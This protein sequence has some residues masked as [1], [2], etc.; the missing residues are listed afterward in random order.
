MNERNP[1]DSKDTLNRRRFMELFAVGAGTMAVA[2]CGGEKKTTPE[3]TS[4][5]LPEHA[6]NS[7]SP[8][9]S[10]TP[11]G[12]KTLEAS[13]FQTME[14]LCKH[15]FDSRIPEGRNKFEAMVIPASA[16]N[17]PQKLGQHFANILET[18]FNVFT[19]TNEQSYPPV[20]EY[21]EV[22]S[23]NRLGEA[24][25]KRGAIKL[26]DE[27]VSY[28]AE[29]YLKGTVFED[30]GVDM[31][32]KPKSLDLGYGLTTYLTQLASSE[33][34]LQKD[35]NAERRENKWGSALPSF[36]SP[37]EPD[38]FLGKIS[39]EEMSIDNA[40]YSNETVSMKFSCR[41]DTE[42]EDS[43]TITSLVDKVG[44]NN[45]GGLDRILG[46]SIKG[47][48]D[49][50]VSFKKTNEGTAVISSVSFNP[51]QASYKEIQEEKQS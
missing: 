48:K 6:E 46:L 42:A 30:P 25:T 50:Y 28:F 23:L 8:E 16:Y 49:G 31:D 27:L 45:I 37:A 32:G 9:V 41:P 36:T 40:Q 10:P 4:G 33:A 26:A 3:Q 13:E 5:Q 20:S 18:S 24:T 15:F 21:Y 1:S 47:I 12:P 34:Y 11:E 2:A 14:S 35:D 43:E 17:D 38:K 29:N 44:N 22:Q 7:P 39:I 19:D 51:H